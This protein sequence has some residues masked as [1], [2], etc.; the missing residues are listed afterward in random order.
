MNVIQLEA[1]LREVRDSNCP[2][3]PFRTISS[4]VSL[5]EALQGCLTTPP[6]TGFLLLNGPGSVYTGGGTSG[7][8][9]WWMSIHI[10]QKWWPGDVNGSTMHQPPLSSDEPSVVT[11]VTVWTGVSRPYRTAPHCVEKGYKWLLL[12]AF[13]RM[14][15]VRQSITWSQN[16]QYVYCSFGLD[17]KLL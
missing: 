17:I 8:V 2:V 11:G 10:E 15:V 6:A 13:Y 7:P 9:L 16:R 3:R 4:I 12:S 5:L 14:E 1:H